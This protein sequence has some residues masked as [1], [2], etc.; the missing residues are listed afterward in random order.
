MTRRYVR[1]GTMLAAGA[2]TASAITG[3]MGPPSSAVQANRIL[4]YPFAE[5][6]AWYVG[7]K[8]IHDAFEA[9]TSGA[10]DFVPN[11]NATKCVDLPGDST[12]KRVNPSELVL[13]VDRGKVVYI[14]FEHH[15][16]GIDHH[17]GLIGYY[18]HVDDI[19]VSEGEVV[20]RDTPLGHPSEKGYVADGCHVHVAFAQ[21]EGQEAPE[22]W[23]SA[24]ADWLPF[25]QLSDRPSP[26]GDP[27]FSGT[28]ASEPPS[29][30]TNSTVRVGASVWSS[31]TLISH[32][33]FTFWWPDLGPE[34][35]PWRIC[36]GKRH[37][38]YASQYYCDIPLVGVPN[39]AA[40]KFSF[41]VWASDGRHTLAPDGLRDAVY[42]GPW[43]WTNPSTG[44]GAAEG[45]TVCTEQHMSG[46]CGFFP[47]GKH[48]LGEFSDRV[49][50]FAIHGDLHAVFFDG[51]GQSGNLSHW[52]DSQMVLAGGYDRSFSSVESY[53][54]IPAPKPTISLVSRPAV[55]V[56]PG[57][58]SFVWI[59]TDGSESSFRVDGGPWTEW[60]SSAATSVSVL[61]T[62][63][64]T[65]DLRARGPG[66]ES[67]ILSYTFES[68]GTPPTVHPIGMSGS[69]DVNRVVRSDVQANVEIDDPGCAD[70]GV[71]NVRGLEFDWQPLQNP[72][73]IR[74]SGVRALFVDATDTVG[75]RVLVGT[76]YW[77]QS[78]ASLSQASGCVNISASNTVLRGPFDVEC[79][80]VKWT[81]NVNIGGP[82]Y[83][84]DPSRNVTSHWS[85][86][87]LTLGPIVPSS[88]AFPQIRYDAELLCALADTTYIGN[89][90]LSPTGASYDGKIICVRDGTLR[91]R[92]TNVTGNVLIVVINGSLIYEGTGDVIASADAAADR[93][94]LVFF[95]TGTANFRG[96]TN[97]NFT[98]H[99]IALAGVKSLGSNCKFHGSL[100]SDVGTDLDMYT[101]GSSLDYNPV[102]AT[103]T[104][105]MPVT[106]ISDAELE[107]ILDSAASGEPTPT[108]VP[109][110]TSSA[111][112]TVSPIMTA[113][114]TPT[115]TPTPTPTSAAPSP[116]ST[117][118][119]ASTTVVSAAGFELR[120]DAASISIRR[121]RTADLTG[122]LN[123]TSGVSCLASVTVQGLPSSFSV[124]QDL[125][126]LSS[127]DSENISIKLWPS[128]STSLGTFSANVVAT[129][130]A[131]ELRLPITVTVVP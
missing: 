125:A 121:G 128:S 70:V 1:L 129:C 114:P 31:S 71:T 16:I 34:Q 119:P 95:T 81:T 77:L 28:W 105:E 59:V 23:V 120:L 122:R 47:V 116:S 100:H 117:S 66:G 6:G 37:P 53:A 107:A 5:S 55:C 75:N 86:T 113:T 40:M 33:N 8:G 112:P 30:I 21:Y 26:S 13:P 91:W 65:F 96:C 103:G 99:V 51:V 12:E 82:I 83:S 22:H 58:Q 89:K 36:K 102:I 62:Q 20:T 19:R 61:G 54:H 84:R 63:G 72:V 60:T 87:G 74:G 41:D 49:R 108:P 90:T 42:L 111:T 98:G 50:S 127:N 80:V 48:D 123:T 110:Q 78:Q 2:L 94:G 131:T 10:K 35:G 93:T 24:G 43:I 67:D 57:S 25:P 39:G 4:Y 68:D 14:D 18:L 76:D 109:S 45:I 27:A 3:V 115:F 124:F 52:D 126:G 118:T 11:S 64:H 106:V 97:A 101:N 130:G 85:N 88:T 9:G 29:L 56:A 17:D 15:E 104:W 44:G 38:V 46:S 32:V 69:R 92:G 7:P 73:V 79:L